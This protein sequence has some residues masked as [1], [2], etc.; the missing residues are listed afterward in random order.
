VIVRNPVNMNE[1]GIIEFPKTKDE[2]IEMAVVGI[3]VTAH[4]GQDILLQVLSTDKW[5]QRNWKL[6]IYGEGH[7]KNYLEKLTHESGL[8]NKI[9]FHG[10]TNDIRSVWQINQILLMPSIMEGMPIAIVEAMLCGRTCV[11]TDVGGITEWITNNDNGFIAPYA[12][13]NS[14][15]EA[16]EKAWQRKDE[17]ESIG[18]KA[19]HRAMEL[20]DPDAG[21]TLLKL[22]TA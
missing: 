15:N 12:T 11:A 8:E 17:W 13:V 5:K 9:R 3:L 7:D 1:T 10:K 4:K 18:K 6:N 2:T 22:I 19:F 16:L 21:N 20:Y 14:I